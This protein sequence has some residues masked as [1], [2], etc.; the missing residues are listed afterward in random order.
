[1]LAHIVPVKRGNIT[2]SAAEVE[3]F[4]VDY[5]NE[6]SFRADYANILMLLVSYHA[7][8]LLEMDEYNQK[9][10]SAYL[11]KPH[12]DAMTYLVNSFERLSMEAEQIKTLARQRGL[13]DKATAVDASMEKVKKIAQNVSQTLQAASQSF[14]S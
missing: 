14:S 5:G 12:A 6:K 11:W 4:R 3:A 9:S 10:T 8:M 13:Q 2:L 7:R 1:K